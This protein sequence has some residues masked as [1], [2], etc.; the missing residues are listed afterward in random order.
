MQQ[1]DFIKIFLGVAFSALIG[2]IC[3]LI[4]DS[5]IGNL[6]V[7]AITLVMLT[8]AVAIKY[9]KHNYIMKATMLIGVLAHIATSLLF[10]TKIHNLEIMSVTLS[11]VTLVTL[12]L[13]YLIYKS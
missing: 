2:Y 12:G 8:S 1:V 11:L 6:I 3:Y 4:D 7:P 13:S 9:A 10:V 5:N